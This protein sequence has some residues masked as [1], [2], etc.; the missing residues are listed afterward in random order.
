MNKPII[1]INAIFTKDGKA[2]R[3]ALDY[4]R[5]IIEAGGLPIILPSSKISDAELEQIINKVDGLLLSGGPDISPDIY[6][7][8]TLNHTIKLLPKIK[9]DFDFRLLKLALKQQLPILGICYGC[10]LLNVALGGSLFQDIASQIKAHKAHRK[11]EHKIYICEGTLLH[12]IVGRNTILANSRHHQSIKTPGRNLMINA[13]CEDNVIEGIEIPYHIN[14]KKGFC[15]GVQWHPESIIDR[16]EHLLLF[17][18]LVKA[19]A[20]IPPTQ[21]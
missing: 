1:A 5:A 7:E 8:T 14:N 21:F 13:R 9:Q 16:E 12:R 10:Q 11:T 3:L 2:T 17:K 18:A 15:L 20:N 4:T 6:G 19:A